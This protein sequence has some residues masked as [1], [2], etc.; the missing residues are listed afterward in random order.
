[1]NAFDQ[2]SVSQRTA[3]L[4]AAMTVPVVA[5]AVSAAG[6]GPHYIAFTIAGVTFAAALVLGILLSASLSR[7]QRQA[8]RAARE[9]QEQ[10]RSRQTTA[11]VNGSGGEEAYFARLRTS[12]DVVTANVMIADENG[13]IL[14]ANQSMNHT[15]R[16]AEADLRKDLPGFSLATLVGSNID[17]FHKNPSHQRNLLANLTGTHTAQLTI[18]G[19]TMRLTMNPLRGPAGEA[20]GTVVEWQ[21]LTVEMGL[22]QEMQGLLSSVVAGDLTRRLPASGG[23]AFLKEMNGYV[24]Q[25]IDSLAEIVAKVKQAASQ[26]YTGAEEISQGNTNLSQ[27]T[28]EQ[29]SSLEET[30]S[31]MEEMTSTVKQNADNAGQANQLAMAARDQAEKG[32]A[33]VSKAVR[34]MHD[35]NDASKKIADII[36][37]I[38]EIAF[39]TNLLALNAAVEAARAGEQGRGFAVVAS[40]VR[41]LAGRSATAAK[42][43]KGL[44]Q[45]SVKKVDDGSLLVTQSGQTLEQIVTSIKKVSDIV[46]EIAAA[47]REQS[48][49]IEQVNRAV[50]QMDELTQQNGALVEQATAASQAMAQQS[51]E[52]N[53]MMD[54]YQL[55]DGQVR[56]AAAAPRAERRGTNRPWTGRKSS[57]AAAP[58]PAPAPAARPAP[59]IVAV[60][61][62]AGSDTEW[63]EF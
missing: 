61:A 31:S 24:N 36:G 40:E 63:T 3:L 38:D 13:N 2:M 8:Q 49:G 57:P 46:A 1:M 27:R 21:D 16:D 11:S 35:I 18:G 17:V 37:V 9:A 14:Y 45:D 10:L 60:S 6:A 62:S 51:R 30:A 41:S 54:R 59:K 5:L 4:L 33:V 25:L 29:S 42:E 7:S 23:N 22:Q 39:Q 43:I 48:A 50:M 55:G 56:A 26:V 53:D 19:R 52:L 20:L 32:G 34:A 58:A 28:E 47:S 12:I 44:I 15:L